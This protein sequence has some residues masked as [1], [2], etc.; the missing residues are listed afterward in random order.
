M[1]VGAPSIYFFRTEDRKFLLQGINTEK[2]RGVWTRES[3]VVMSDPFI[4][5]LKDGIL[6]RSLCFQQS[7]WIVKAP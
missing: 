1:R 2:G 3:S 4:P 6:E 5:T 7:T